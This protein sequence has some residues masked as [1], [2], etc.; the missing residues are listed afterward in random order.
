MI[1][2]IGIVDYHIGNIQSVINAFSVFDNVEVSLVSDPEELSSCYA[3]VLPGVGNFQK[4]MEKLKKSGFIPFLNKEVLEKKK[5]CL[6]ICLGMQL[7]AE[8][9]EE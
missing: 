9:S 4:A 7:F 3:F 5:P 8:T 1:R 6:G 2:K